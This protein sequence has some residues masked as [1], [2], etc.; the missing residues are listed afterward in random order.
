MNELI[1]TDILKG[2]TLDSKFLCRLHQVLGK[3]I[4]TAEH[5]ICTTFLRKTVQT[6]IPLRKNNSY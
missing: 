6:N 5:V 1:T 3:G 4:E 2:K